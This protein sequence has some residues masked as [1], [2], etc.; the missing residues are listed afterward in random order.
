MFVEEKEWRRELYD[1]VGFRTVLMPVIGMSKQYGLPIRPPRVTSGWG[2]EWVYGILISCCHLH[3]AS[4]VAEPTFEDW[5]ERP[6]LFY[7]RGG[8]RPCRAGPV[9][10]VHMRCVL[11]R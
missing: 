9:T 7:F 4:M 1:P 8:G 10:V 3:F 2:R 11:V 5:L 6:G